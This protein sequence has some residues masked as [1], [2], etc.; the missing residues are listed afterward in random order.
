VWG[1]SGLVLVSCAELGFR[2]LPSLLFWSLVCA[3]EA[4][5][6]GSIRG[7]WLPASRYDSRAC[8]LVRFRLE[9][10]LSGTLAKGIDSLAP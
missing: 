7:S 10:I 5:E 4:R 3:P 1:I 8:A 6:N 2:V 9:G